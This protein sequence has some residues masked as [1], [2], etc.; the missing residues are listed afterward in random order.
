LIRNL[1]QIFICLTDCLTGLVLCWRFSFVNLCISLCWILRFNHGFIVRFSNTLYIFGCRICHCLIFLNFSFIIL[2]RYTQWNYF[3]RFLFIFCEVLIFNIFGFI[4]FGINLVFDYRIDTIH[5]IMFS[6]LR[7]LVFLIKSFILSFF[8][9][10]IWF[11]FRIVFFF[12]FLKVGV[13]FFNFSFNF[14]N[15]NWGLSSF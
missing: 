11:M 13:Y 6:I 2:L 12:I 14:F 15:F 1:G 8:T 10:F 5:L 3:N 7:F 9:L 4:V